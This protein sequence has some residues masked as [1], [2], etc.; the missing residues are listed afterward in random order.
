MPDVANQLGGI[1]ITNPAAGEA[2]AVPWDP[3]DK[4]FD[5]TICKANFQ[6]LNL[7]YGTQNV[8][9]STDPKDGQ[10]P[11]A[12]WAKTFASA[13]ATTGT[14]SALPYKWVRITLKGNLSGSPYVGG[15]F[16]AS[17][18]YAA[19]ITSPGITATDNR[20]VCWNG[21]Q[22]V[23]LPVGFTDCK[24]PPAGSSADPLRPVFLLTALSRMPSGSER[25]LS[26]EVA[27][28]PPTIVHGAVVSNDVIDTVGSSATFIGAD[29]C[30]CSCDPKTNVCT[31]RVGGGACSSGYSA[32]TTSQ[33]VSSS[34]QPTITP[35]TTVPPTPGTVENVKP[36]PYDIPTLINRYKTASGTVNAT[37][38]PYNLTCSGSPVTCGSVN[39]G[40]FGTEPTNFPP[41]PTPVGNVNQTTYVPGNLDL[42]AHN[43]GSGILV[44][45][46]DLVIHGG[47]EF[48]GLII[49]KGAVT[50]TGG[51]GG[52]GSNV[53]GAILAGQSAQADT[54][55]GSVNL[56]FDQCA[57]A[58]AQNG[59]PP[60]TL[61]SRE[62]EY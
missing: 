47:L 10:S 61:S 2:A 17:Y 21:S 37:G 54:L 29:N 15:A 32:I 48:Y 23:L 53:I 12:Q 51:G 7:G 44:V 18:P 27:D 58:N 25:T 31:N 14:A 40:T 49:V 34:G 36:F 4:Y 55:G 41:N 24:T 8:R 56:Q 26:I 52:G 45:D 42:Q 46:G 59:Q 6:K 13:S 28:D 19:D 33:T 11:T 1:Y 50:F 60:R 35:P 39:G 20:Q 38:A 16:P 22:Q 30:S 5:D 3:A 62:I 9:C 57:L 43:T